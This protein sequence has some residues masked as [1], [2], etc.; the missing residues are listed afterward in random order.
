MSTAAPGPGEARIP[1]V[2]R[3]VGSVVG[4]LL[5]DLRP[6]RRKWARLSTGVKAAN[7]LSA[8]EFEEL[9]QHQTRTESWDP[10]N[11]PTE[12]SLEL[13]N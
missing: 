10:T 12:R 13:R 3:L 4:S 11:A 1:A 2:G 7:K 6:R 5:T 9:G 8:N